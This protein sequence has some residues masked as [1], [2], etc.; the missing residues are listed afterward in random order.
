MTT[1][2]IIGNTF[3]VKE[4]LKAMGGRWNPD[5]RGWEVPSDKAAEAQALVD[6][7]PVKRRGGNPN[8]RPRQYVNL[9]GWTF[10][11]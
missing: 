6:A 3:P 9:S 11:G 4:Q 5:E 10:R 8:W 1:T 2:I 7:Q